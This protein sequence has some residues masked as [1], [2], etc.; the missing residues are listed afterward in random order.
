[1]SPLSLQNLTTSPLTT[2]P[3]LVMILSGCAL[4]L[5]GHTTTAE[6]QGVGLISGGIGLV[7]A[8]Q[9]NKSSEDVGVNPPQS[10]GPA[11]VSNPFDPK[12]PQAA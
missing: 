1:M 11:R 9:N 6:T 7:F 2:I 10:K 8:R 3:G 5:W 4:I 12:P